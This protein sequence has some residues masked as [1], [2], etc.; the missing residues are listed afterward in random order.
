MDDIGSYFGHTGKASP[1][2]HLSHVETLSLNHRDLRLDLGYECIW[3]G[4]PTVWSLVGTRINPG[5]FEAAEDKKA[6]FLHGKVTLQAGK[7]IA[8]WELE[9]HPIL[10]KLKR[11]TVGSRGDRIWD[12]LKR[13]KKMDTALGVKKL[14]HQLLALSTVYHYCES[15]LLGPL[16]LHNSIIKLKHPPKTFTYHTLSLYSV[17]A[18]FETPPVI[19]GA[20]NRHIYPGIQFCPDPD[21]PIAFD[22]M[23]I[24][25]VSYL[26]GRLLDQFESPAV[27]DNGEILEPIPRDQYGKTKIEL[28]DYIRPVKFCLI[29]PPTVN[30]PTQCMDVV[31]EMFDH[32]M[33]QWADLIELKSFESCPPCSA[34]GFDRLSLGTDTCQDGRESI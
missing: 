9:G 13:S 21:D 8:N 14:P 22:E 10:P 25:N 26:A 27:D 28:Y 31:R 3:K 34:C 32:L 24:D 7:P 2:A 1:P 4:A 6:M 18:E 30:T 23:V 15:I 5:D 16:A 17:A 11:V 19:I 20:I 29:H 12:E 33:G